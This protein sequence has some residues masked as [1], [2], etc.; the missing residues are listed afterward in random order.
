MNNKIIELGRSIL[1]SPDI[2]KN[3]LQF[4]VPNV[5]LGISKK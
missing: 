4:F 2:Q 5:N 1:I 3:V